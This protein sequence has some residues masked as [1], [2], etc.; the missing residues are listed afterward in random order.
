[1]T[2]CYDLAAGFAPVRIA[3][4]GH[5]I[6]CLWCGKPWPCLGAKRQA[7]ATEVKP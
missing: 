6:R 7:E 2:F 1:M 5:I 4:P 3:P